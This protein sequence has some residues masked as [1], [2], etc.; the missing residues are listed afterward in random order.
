VVVT[1]YLLGGGALN[2]FALV[3]LL[4]IVVGTY[5]SLFV[6][7]PV[8]MIVHRKREAAKQAEREAAA[9]AASSANKATA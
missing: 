4:G 8:M 6:A 1:L 5:S 9:V 7:T 3:L 2:D